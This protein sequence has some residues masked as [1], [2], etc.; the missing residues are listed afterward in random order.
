MS[1]QPSN[2][3]SALAR[4]GVEVRRVSEDA[5]EPWER[6]TSGGGG[7]DT[8]LS[9]SDSHP[10]RPEAWHDVPDLAV[11]ALAKACGTTKPSEL[12]VIP[13]AARSVAAPRNAERQIATPLQV[14]GF[15]QTAIGLWADDAFGGDLKVVIPI[16]ELA[17]IEDVHVLLF[18]RLSLVTSRQ[19]LTIRYN[20]VAGHKLEESLQAVR[21][22]AAGT[23]S[24]VHPATLPDG[25]PH[26]WVTLAASPTVRLD[27]GPITL[28]YE[29]EP[30]RARRE[31][32]YETLIALTAHEL[33]IAREPEHRPVTAKYGVDVLQVPLGRLEGVW[34][35]GDQ[36]CVRAAGAITR[37]KVGPAASRRVAELLDTQ[38]RPP[39][40]I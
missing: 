11:N 35:E 20:T 2:E 7:P 38:A 34:T 3:I 5:P 21:L 15:G 8:G 39:A 32:P 18:G 36:L 19:R 1:H 14:L 6:V 31:P 10:F 16:D 22:A 27:D 23:P 24:P 30:G 37:V 28:V 29:T 33:V 26:K 40:Q 17:A 13:P 12:F 25:T 9:G 4:L